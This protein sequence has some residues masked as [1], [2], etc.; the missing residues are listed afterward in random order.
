MNRRGDFRTLLSGA[1]ARD[2]STKPSDD[3]PTFAVKAPSTLELG[4]VISERP[5][6]GFA[7]RPSFP[8]L[9]GRGSFTTLDVVSGAP[10][11]AV[12]GATGLL[13]HLPAAELG[14]TQEHSGRYSAEPNSELGRGGIGRVFVALD[15]HLGRNVAVKELLLDAPDDPGRPGT[16]Q[17][18]ARFLREARITGQLDHPNIVPVYE[19]GRRP[20]GSLYYTMRVVRGR[21]LAQ[22]LSDAKTLPERLALLSHF[23]GLC[24]AIAYAHSRGVVHRDIKPEN[25]MIGEFGET[26]VLDWGMAKAQGGEIET[27]AAKP[28][29]DPLRL[30][31]TVDGSLCGTPT[32]MSPEQARGATQEVDERSDVWALGV[33]LYSLLAGSN[34]FGGK[35]LSDLIQRILRGKYAPLAS[36]D[37]AIPP[38]LAAIA[39]RALKPNRAERY[40]NAREL[41]RDVE[42]YR[43]GA[44]VG[45][46]AYSTLDL[47]KRFLER[48][49]TAAVASGVG[50]TVAL[51]LAV[52]SY[53]RLAAARDRALAA[54]QRATQ[55]ERE[56]RANERAAKQ[57]LSYVLV[58]KAQQAMGEG[59]RTSAAVLAARALELGEG[60]EARGIVLA[61]DG[62]FRPQPKSVHAASVG[63]KETALSYSAGLMACARAETLTLYDLRDGESRGTLAPRGN[64][65]AFDL[66]RD[67]KR[68]VVAREDGNVSVFAVGSNGF[69]LL[70]ERSIGSTAR[71]S[72]SPDGHYVACG[73]ASGVLVWQL[74]DP[75]RS[76]RLALRQ[77]LA[78]LAFEPRGNRLVI[79][80]ELGLVSLWDYRNDKQLEL[81]GHTGTV[82]ALAFAQEGRLLATGAEDHSIRFWDSESGETSAAPIVYSDAITS[83]SWSE[84]AR[85]LAFGSKDK[86]VHLVDLKSSDR[87]SSVV[88]YHDDVVE[89][90]ALSADTTEL[91]SVSRDLGVALWSLAGIRKPAELL[92]RGNVLA[93]T[94]TP[95]RRE[96]ISVGLGA[97]GVGLWNLD[98]LECDT[99]LPAGVDR[100]RAVGTSP[101]GKKLAFAGSA[102]RVSL[103]D[104]P[105]RI[106]LRVFENGH[107]EV[108]SL[109]FSADS[110][111]LAWGGL[112]RQLR[113]VDSSTFQEVWS[114][115]NDSPL[116]A[117][118]FLGAGS[119]LVSGDRDGNLAGFDVAKKRQLFRFKAHD[120][121]VL[122]VSP[123]RDGKRVATGSGD[124]H[125]KVWD[126]NDGRMVFD[127][128]GHE[129]KVLALD[130]SPRAPLLASG[131]EDKSV[132][133]WDLASG[134]ELAVLNGHAGAV[135]SVR[136]SEQAELLAS[137]GDDGTIR[138]WRL[139]ALTTPAAEL[140]VNIEK[141]FRVE[142]V[143]TR[144][145]RARRH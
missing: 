13:M 67:G 94:F 130:T 51:V 136:F 7:G 47:L 134:R 112:D 65:V 25:V 48:H 96:L 84:D 58:E 138:L 123:T 97:N 95:G 50:L 108:R 131:S 126:P 9:D 109:S 20:D 113:V 142:L 106:P 103:W 99:R 110:R 43:S 92:E 124:R 17:T 145:V 117:V 98:S 39:E 14:V 38:E 104:L 12:N 121:W 68:V 40:A 85:I 116:Q 54:E 143:G 37:P 69:E 114:V 90:V 86:S 74:N 22:A 11:A 62:S 26:V 19:L 127:L 105:S 140:S 60:A 6:D 122:A 72:L 31:L 83:L 78:A 35:T 34:P 53:A 56:A 107:D 70:A 30:D 36:V 82:R 118:A 44:R 61:S 27:V 125:V 15:R 100:L 119:S 88:R 71:V 52:A 135:R 133:L 144:V 1:P 73:G 23:V 10:A 46:Y 66:A 102:N 4:P 21:T 87:K 139:E 28:I 8:T 16:L 59:D 141:R 91:A 79:T 93:L 75:T 111:W 57:S 77:K 80:G 81:T 3:P 128:K 18:V 89:R 63:C 24:Q 29:Q 41:L 137:A 2:P 132:R 101:D 32:H 33:V 76:H 42:A 120:D 45:A 5:S 115:A 55:N 64:I 129:G 49:R